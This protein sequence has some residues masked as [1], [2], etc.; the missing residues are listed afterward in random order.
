MLAAIV[1]AV[2]V[3]TSAPA[4]ALPAGWQALPES[5]RAALDLPDGCRVHYADTSTITCPDGQVIVS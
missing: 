5:I 1:L 2:A 3:A 4:P